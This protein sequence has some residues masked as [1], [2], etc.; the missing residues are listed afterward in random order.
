MLFCRDGVLRLQEWDYDPA[1]RSGRHVLLPLA[2]LCGLDPHAFA[3]HLTREIAFEDDLTVRELFLN[4][5]PWAAELEGLACMDFAAFVA[6][7]EKPL[8]ADAH[9]D[10]SHVELSASIE[11]AAEPEFEEDGDDLLKT[12]PVAGG[13]LHQWVSP[14]PRVSDRIAVEHRWDSTAIYREPQVE[15]VGD[16]RVTV[17]SCSLDYSPLTRWH[18]LPIR[19]NPV[20]VLSDDTGGTGSEY[21]SYGVPLL[22]PAHPRVTAVRHGDGSRIYRHEVAVEAPTP[23]FMATLVRGFFWDVGFHYS[24]A[25]RDEQTRSLTAA[26]D[27]VDRLLAAMSRDGD[28]GLDGAAEDPVSEEVEGGDRDGPA[29]AEPAGER[30]WLRER[31]E[32]CNQNASHLVRWLA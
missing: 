12:I 6:E 17:R 23:T 27:D 14:T 9:T 31:I 18:H 10:L 15:Q 16:T 5:K 24:P 20:M 21:L 2:V 11:I 22:N 3:K 13:R 7:A 28:G 30:A 25:G 8:A 26:M 4:L 32:Y 29:A 1:T 19:L